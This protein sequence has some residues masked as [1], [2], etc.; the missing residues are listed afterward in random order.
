MSLPPREM[1]TIEDL[2]SRWNIS[3]KRVE[4][5]LLTV[6]LQASVFLPK[7]VLLKYTLKFNFEC[8]SDDA[9]PYCYD[10]DY[11]D[12]ESFQSRQG[13]FNLNYQ[14]IKWS[15]VGQAQLEKGEMFLTLPGEEAY[16]GFNETFILN[17]DEVVITLP[18]ITRFEEEHSITAQTLNDKVNCQETI[19][20]A[21]PDKDPKM[22]PKE[23]ESLLKMIIAMAINGYAFDPHEK[24]SVIPVGIVED[25]D[26]LGLSIDADTVRKWLKEAAALLRKNFV[27]D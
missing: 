23:K 19:A 24:K 27:M 22:N 11:E 9:D 15:E 18:E 2:A 7:T 1:Y 3:N 4:E 21:S 17:R 14:N 16:F 10:V 12:P 20:N 8:N 13:L 26:R 6:K 25:V 5:Y